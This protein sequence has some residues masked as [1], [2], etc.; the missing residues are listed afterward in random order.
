MAIAFVAPTAGAVDPNCPVPVTAPQGGIRACS[1]GHLADLLSS[2]FRGRITIPRDVAWEMKA[3]NGEPLRNLTVKS[4]V[5]IVGE[6]G[7]LGSR[8]TL[9]SKDLALNYTFFN[10]TGSDVRISG[11]RLIGPKP[12]ADHAR[13]SAKVNGVQVLE[14]FDAKL[15]RRVVLEENEIEQ[16]S[17]AAV[18]VGGTHEVDTPEEW[19][20]AWVK[21]TRA[22]APLVR[23]ERNYLHDNVMDEKG[24]GVVLAGGAFATVT[25]NVFQNNRHAVAA[26]GKAFSGY[27]ATL[28]YILNAGIKENGNFYN[29]HFDV[30]GVG[31]GGYGGGA[32]TFFDIAS[33]TIRGEQSYYLFKTRPAVMLRG[34]P[35]DGMLFRDNVLVHDDLDAAVALDGGGWSASWGE[36]NAKFNF[37]PGRNW[38]DKDYS[39]EI[40]SGDFDG[41]GRTDVF[42]SNGTGWWW[43]RAGIT[44][45]ELL[46]PS[47]TRTGDLKFADMDGDRR[48]DV[49]IRETNGKVGYYSGGQ[50]AFVPLSGG[51]PV[52]PAE[53][54]TGDFDGDQKTDLFYT[55]KSQWYV[56]YAKTRT[57]TPTASSNAK[58]TELLF[59][60][61]DTV[62]G[63]DVVAVRNNQ[64]S[65]SSA[66]TSQW[67]RL[68]A[69][70]TSNFDRS[71]VADFNGDGYDDIGID[72]GSSWRYVPSGRLFPL[73]LRSGNSIPPMK[74]LQFGRFD[75]GAKA[76]AV[77]FWNDRLASWRGMGSADAFVT[78]SV[79]DMR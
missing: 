49:V 28:N 71:V 23:I 68:N 40:A 70:Y 53:L 21:P 47:T 24:Y 44:Q 12:A 20:P 17:G 18:R 46:R 11:L 27:V 33:N 3:A 61:F 73:K 74:S 1:A 54:R 50:G 31:K 78:R 10:V 15:G 36:D 79:Q 6:R 38:F 22:D 65:L 77:G 66:S 75:T 13:T 76:V 4:G 25:G 57:W 30:H 8:P 29:Q 48:T 5:E 37:R 55:Y 7:Y 19:D 45:W 39:K 2:D 56:W 58:V 67:K 62:K 60:D 63:T 26:S 35:T 69:K 52:P 34:K 9:Y 43:S 16:F 14:D 59:G 42:L 64:W 32:G 41:D 51:I 72:D